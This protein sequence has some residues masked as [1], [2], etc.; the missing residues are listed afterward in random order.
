MSEPNLDRSMSSVRLQIN[1]SRPIR[2]IPQ[3]CDLTSIHATQN[4]QATGRPPLRPVAAARSMT[5]SRMV[6][7][8]RPN[9]PSNRP[10]V[11]PMQFQ[12]DMKN[13]TNNTNKLRDK[14]APLKGILINANA[15]PRGKFR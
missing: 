11:Q 12:N 1:V 14:N 3:L 10:N 8:G 4:N 13:E 7:N 9:I 6:S 2:S 5:S 15:G